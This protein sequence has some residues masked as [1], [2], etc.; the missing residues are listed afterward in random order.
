M[1]TRMFPELHVTDVDRSAAL[2]TDGLGFKIEFTFEDEGVTDF[3]VLRNEDLTLYLHHML[4]D[5]ESG[6]P[7]RM[8]LYFELDDIASFHS[9]LKAKGYDVSDIEH[10]TYGGGAKTC[11]LVGPDAYEIWF[12]EWQ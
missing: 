12:Q 1:F 11:L 6:N 10:Q 5:D 2:F 4:P 9:E 8:R 7:K 3:A